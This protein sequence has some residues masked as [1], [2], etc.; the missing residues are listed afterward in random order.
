MQKKKQDVVHHPNHYQMP[1]GIEVID[2][3]RNTLG[4]DGFIAY[5]QGNV[6]KYVCR[7]RMK[8]GVEDLQK[9]MVYTSM[10]IEEMRKKEKEWKQE[11]A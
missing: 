3:I 6:M 1:G 10:M 8:N 9:A 7:Y 5:C 11:R 4:Y 2:M